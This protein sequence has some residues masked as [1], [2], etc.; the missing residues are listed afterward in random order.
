[1]KLRNLWKPI[2]H[3]SL[4]LVVAS[5][6][7]CSDDATPAD[8]SVDQPRSDV[9]DASDV[10]DV[11]DATD[12][13][14]VTDV[15]DAPAP[16]PRC[17]WDGGAPSATTLSIGRGVALSLCNFCHQDSTPGAGEFSGQTSPRPRTTA[18]GANLTPDMMTGIGARTDEQVLRAI[19]QGVAADGAR[20]L[21]EMT[22][23]TATMV[24]DENLCAL[25]AYLRSLTPVSRAIPASTCAR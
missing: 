3:W 4:A 12:A 11:S 13:T 2:V 21:C 17:D 18:Y 14:D 5:S 9:S 6:T 15:T 19:R 1:M 7:A 20:R 25:L 10:T 24:P 16:L 8:A 23:F 22:P